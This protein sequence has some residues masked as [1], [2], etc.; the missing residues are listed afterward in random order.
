MD[1]IFLL[2]HIY[3]GKMEKLWYGIASWT[4]TEN[5]QKTQKSV[6]NW[7][8]FCKNS[9]TGYILDQIFYYENVVPAS[10]SGSDTNSSKPLK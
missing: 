5:E 4:K 1:Q 6:S 10:M 3:D 8:L 7:N 2:L 9:F